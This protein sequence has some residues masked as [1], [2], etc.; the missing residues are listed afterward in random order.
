MA[1]KREPLLLPGTRFGRYDIARELG[2]GGMGAV[3]EA[4]HIEL[5]KRVAIKVLLPAMVQNAE[6]RTRFLREGEA[7]AKIRHTHA[8]DVYD[9]GVENG[10]AYLVMEFLE[11]EDLNSVLR[12]DGALDFRR[13]TSILLPVFAA[14][15]AAHDEGVIHRDLKPANIFLSKGRRGDIVPKVLDFGISKIVTDDP[16]EGLT[17]TGTVL[18][19]PYYMSPEQA[20]GGK[21]VDARS[22]Q[23]SLGVIMYQCVTGRRP[24]QA[25]S[26]YQVLHQIVEGAFDP[27]RALRPE[28]DP[29]LEAAILR[30][31][32]K[33]PAERF[34]SVSSFAN[35]L[36]PYATDRAQVLW[37][38]VFGEGRPSMD[39]MDPTLLKP[40]ARAQS[41]TLPETRDEGALTP[42][43]IPS[44]P[45]SSSSPSL[46]KSGN[47]GLAGAPQPPATAATSIAPEPAPAALSTL[48]PAVSQKIAPPAQA[49][50]GSPLVLVAAVVGVV[51]LGGG[52]AVLLRGKDEAKVMPATPTSFHAHV[53]VEPANAAITVDGAAAGAGQFDSEFPL[54]G[55]EHTLVARAGGYEPVTIV[56]KNAPPAERITLSPLKEAVAAPPPAPT[57]AAPAAPSG[58]TSPAAAGHA[59][60]AHKAGHARGGEPKSGGGAKGVNDALIIE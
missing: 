44:G 28:L 16:G 30:S 25:P 13:A 50:K 32:R 23:Y 49:P 5:K 12:R 36:I 6:A 1:E 3:Y 19:T 29:G 35:A 34:R 2:A 33:D 24:F 57:G 31:M 42:S 17:S 43:G 15:Q 59:P 8:V 52:A 10:M 39:P 45:I 22:D 60:S 37:A 9:V 18:G 7:A 53:A 55:R 51:I 38:P 56:F 40:A 26:M 14:M 41:N 11:G 4:T 21:A 47:K 54:D 46:G 27:P 20:H 58:A 48:N